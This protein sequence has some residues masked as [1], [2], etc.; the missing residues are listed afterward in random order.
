MTPPFADIIEATK[1]R[2]D[3]PAVSV[4]LPDGTQAEMVYDPAERKTSFAV[5]SKG[6]VRYEDRLILD[7]H[8]VVRP[9]SEANSLIK[10]QIVLLPSRADPYDSEE[11]LLAEIRAFI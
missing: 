7:Q 3:T 1:G 8:T 11:T 2:R 5:A 4:I 10:H 9:Y 6:E